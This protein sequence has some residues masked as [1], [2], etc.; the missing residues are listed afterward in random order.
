MAEA[1]P[2]VEIPE[3]PIPPGAAAEWFE[4]TDGARLRA[5]L[6]PAMGAP[7]GSVVLSGG[8]TEPIEKYF[9]VIGELQARGFTVLAHDWRGQGLSARALPDRLKGHADGFQPFLDDYRA[10][11]AAF[12]ARLPK[13]WI[14]LGH[15]MGGCLTLLALGRG[16]A[17]RFAAGVLSA[18]MLGLQLPLPLPVA[19]GLA[20]FFCAVGRRHGY[21]FLQEGSPF[22]ADFEGNRLTHDERRFL[23]HRHQIDACPD[24]ALGSV[25]WGWLDFATR[26]MTENARPERLARVAIPMLV[27]SAEADQIVEVAAQARAA[28]RLPDA[29]YVVVPGARH[30]ILMETDERRAVVWAAFDDLADRVAPK[31]RSPSA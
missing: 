27:Y 24:L 30:E 16:E 12:E 28:E 6:F 4:G 14:A 20:R 26:A 19:R 31:L 21:V 29:R 1:A 18:P 7:R 10:L 15:S 13:P 23:R 3:A 2:L 25:T 5:A 9:E 22:D 17:A 8:R 11:L